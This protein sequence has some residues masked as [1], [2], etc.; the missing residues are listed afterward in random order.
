MDIDED[1]HII[2]D[3]GFIAIQ[4]IMEEINCLTQDN[5]QLFYLYKQFNLKF[6]NEEEKTSLDNIINTLKQKEV[7]VNMKNVNKLQVADLGTTDPL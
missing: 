4:T 6:F 5:H 3:D 7:K 2:E 1:T